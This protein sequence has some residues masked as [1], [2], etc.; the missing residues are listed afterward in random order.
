MKAPSPDSPAT[1]GQ[2]FHPEAGQQLILAVICLCAGIVPFARW[3]PG[4]YTRIVYTAVFLAFALFARNHASLRKY[5][6]LSFAFFILGLIAVLQSFV[7]GYVE[8]LSCTTLRM[9]AIRSRRRFW[10]QRL[11]SFS[12]PSVQLCRSSSSPGSREA[13]WA[14]STSAKACWVAGLFLPWSSLLCSISL[15]RLSRF[16]RTAQRNASFPKVER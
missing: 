2:R 16:D 15:W 13:I 8:R 6:E 9:V 7:N 1:Q 10:E 5:W 14:P 4:D 11:F 3:I 12:T